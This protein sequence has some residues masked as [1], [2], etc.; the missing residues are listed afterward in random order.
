MKIELNV[1]EQ[2]AQEISKA[3]TQQLR[4][5]PI[6]V[7]VDMDA[8]GLH[9]AEKILPPVFSRIEGLRGIV[10]DLLT[11]LEAAGQKVNKPSVVKVTPPKSTM[12]QT[13]VPKPFSL[14][15]LERK[16]RKSN[17]VD[18]ER[19]VSITEGTATCKEIGQ[20][21]GLTPQK[22]RGMANHLGI[23]PAGK[24]V[25][26]RGARGKRGSVPGEPSTNGTYSYI[27][28]GIF[29]DY[30]HEKGFLAFT[31]E[32]VE[33]PVRLR[34]GGPPHRSPGEIKGKTA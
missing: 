27:Q 22:I 7:G 19:V 24:V 12:V 25:R 3:V 20:S 18:N 9:I 21:L 13:A 29:R 30:A 8:L 17:K 16:P 23:T 4:D 2:I 31:K 5:N 33:P 32:S 1:E 14:Q 10:L 15:V 34:G 11:Y 28:W 6:R 26:R